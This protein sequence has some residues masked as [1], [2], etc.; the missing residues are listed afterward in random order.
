MWM[1]VENPDAP[2]VKMILDQL[3]RPQS[4]ATRSIDLHT[5]DAR[6]HLDVRRPVETAS[7]QPLINS[8]VHWAIGDAA[9]TIPSLNESGAKPRKICTL[10]SCLSSLR[11]AE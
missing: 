3:G 11:D 9:K 8:D 7:D 2:F 10:A 1:C 4:K 6:D 5:V